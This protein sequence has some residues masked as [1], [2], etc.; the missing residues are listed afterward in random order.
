MTTVEIVALVVAFCLQA[1][2]LLNSA[3]PLWQ[4]LPD[5]AQALLPVLVAVL[6]QLASALTGAKSWM[7][8]AEAVVIAL[9]M[10]LPGMHTRS[11]ASQ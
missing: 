7:D 5:R 1:T 2:R 10:L 3:K 9:A 4:M 8:L 6:P 11:R